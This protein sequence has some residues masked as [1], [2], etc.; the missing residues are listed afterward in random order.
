[1]MKKFDLQRIKKWYYLITMLFNYKYRKSFN[2]VKHN[3]R[4]LSTEA[5]EEL[6]ESLRDNFFTD[7]FFSSDYL[8]SEVGK[9]DMEDHVKI[10]LDNYRYETIPWL[11][12]IMN[13]KDIRILDIGCGTGCTTVA[14]AEQGAIVTGIDFS[15]TVLE[16]AK[17]RCHLYEIT[18]GLSLLNAT[19]LNDL[20]QEFDMVVFSAC[21]EH[22]TYKERLLS[23]RAAWQ[24]LATGGFL[25]VVDTPNRLHY[26]DRHSS[27]LPF[28]DWL[29]DELALQYS[30][31]S[32]RKKCIELSSSNDIYELMRFGRGVS[33]HEFELAL[34]IEYDKMKINS[35]Q[36]F[37][38][39]IFTRFIRYNRKFMK[40][41]KRVGPN[42]MQ[43]GFYYDYLFLCIKKLDA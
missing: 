26:Y 36:S 29:P 20:N 38:N 9:K 23:I 10:R 4:Y 11:N 6:R 18:A 40:Q 28:Y 37:T 31:Y 2:R 25:V 42:M 19:N 39:S 24:V 17:K 27:M 15:A 16:V 3:F 43:E 30:K 1:M 33:Y 22:M 41:L 7:S 13:L 5:T 12:S 34:D 21:L 32:P 8:Y 35:M 14:L